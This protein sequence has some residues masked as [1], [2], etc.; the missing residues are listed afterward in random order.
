[1]VDFLSENPLVLLIGACEIG[2][3]V[4]LLGGL[5]ARYLLRARRLSTVLLLA[6]PVL[7]VVLVSASLI[8][9]AGGSAPGLTHGL[10]AV[11]LGFT[12]A[13][14]H[15]MIRWAD[16]RFAHRFAGGP[17]PV[18]APRYGAA[19]VRHEWREWGR[20][21]LAWAIAIVVL[22][23]TAAVA[24]TGVPDPLAWTADPMWSWAARLVPVIV[25]WLAVGPLWTTLSPPRAPEDVDAHR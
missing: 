18:G 10:A 11:Y 5:A 16:A 4:L 21:V 17:A 1:M 19:K 22:V 6:V 23:V 15:T 9:V 25:I 12:V 24:G 2:F 7:D 14:G 13:F 20:L 8:D 3:W